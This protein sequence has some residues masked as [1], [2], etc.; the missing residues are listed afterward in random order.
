MILVDTSVWIDHLRTANEA[1]SALLE[2][3]SVLTHP[4]VTGEI[5]LGYLRRREAILSA[6]RDLPQAIVATDAE[7]LS[8]IEEQ[9]LAGLGMG[10]IDVHLLASVRL[11]AGAAL[12]TRDKRLTGV[13]E[14][15]GVGWS[16][17]ATP[18][19]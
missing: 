8:F 18:P 2:T 13:A 1:L 5:A 3:G 9:A 11:T 4:F 6:L 19:R 14:R 12:W 10:Y 15:L 7:V 17:L 16:G